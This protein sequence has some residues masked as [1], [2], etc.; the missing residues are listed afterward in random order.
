VI[1][2]AM[3]T[4][5]ERG[6]DLAD[7]PWFDRREGLL[8]VVD[9]EVGP[10]IDMHTHLAMAPAAAN[11]AIS[12]ACCDGASHYLP[13]EDPLD[14]DVYAN[15]NI[16]ER[17]LRRMKQDLGFGAV[18][19]GAPALTHS[20]DNLLREMAALGIV[21]SVLLPIDAPWPNRRV[22]TFLRAAADRPGLV[23]FGSV[24]A[25]AGAPGDR[26]DDQLGMGARGVKLHPAVQMVRPDHPR[27]MASYSLC[28]E[29]EMPV[30]IHCGPVGIE[31]RIGRALSQLKHYW[32][33]IA[34]NPA[35]TFLLGHSGGLQFDLALEL[36]QRYD[37]VW[38][39]LSC[40]SV[41][42][43]R[44]MVDSAPADRIVLGSDWPWYHQAMPIAKVLMATD[45]LG[46]A[47]KRR[48]RRRILHDNAA[49]LLGLS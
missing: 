7:L 22:E 37:N 23:S 8:T 17:N 28:A 21:T 27:A 4:R 43:V 6:W 30:L 48:A 20:P 39:E 29:R 15:E 26:L 38:L 12:A 3:R 25:F 19:P 49:R 11:R 35:V 34:D 10:V 31:P 36:A 1:A 5:F 41:S 47:D 24:H 46:K 9:D 13:M 42:N 18:L 33:A 44:K 40:Q 16:S 32:R 2:R 45:H 14:L